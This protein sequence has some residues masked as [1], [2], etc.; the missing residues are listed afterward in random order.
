MRKPTPLLAIA[1]AATC[2]T[3]LAPSAAAAEKVTL[4]HVSF[5]ERPGLSTV[6]VTPVAVPT[7]QLDVHLG[8]GDFLPSGASC[9]AGRYE[10]VATPVTFPE[11]ESFCV[12]RRG[13]HLASVHSQ[14]ENDLI[15]K[16]IDPYGDGDLQ[17]YIGGIPGNA[18]PFFDDPDETYAWT[19]GTPWDYEN[20]R[21][22]TGEP[23]GG[24]A[25]QLW[26]DNAKNRDHGVSYVGWNDVDQ[27][28]EM[29]FVCKT[30]G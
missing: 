23:Y 1:L 22:S 5:S 12:K 17:A 2:L 18:G 9:P 20:W 10:Y 28:T 27:D 11:A 16:L 4:C 14:A 7:G 13:G 24:D 30:R 19:D 21:R 25:I 29:P 6:V 26:P 3:P 15:G 8:H